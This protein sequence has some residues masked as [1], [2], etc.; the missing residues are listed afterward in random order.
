MRKEGVYLIK[1][2]KAI[3]KNTI[4]ENLKIYILLGVVCLL[5]IIVAIMAHTKPVAEEEI[6]IYITEFMG[7]LEHAGTDGMKSF[8]YA[9]LAHIRFVVVMLLSSLTIVGVP[10]VLIYILCIGFS[11]GTVLS[12]LFAVFSGKA[13][14][15]FLCAMLPHLLISLPCCMAYSC[16]CMK[17]AYF[18][19]LGKRNFKKNCVSP[20]LTGIFFLLVMSVAAMVQAYVEPILISWIS[21]FFIQG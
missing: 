15:F 7:D 18:L 21:K 9:M 11:Y 14:L 20:F 4:E 17:S 2:L 8:Y 12:S 3:I 5:G 13:L 10:I 1:E 19:F 6:R 16:Y